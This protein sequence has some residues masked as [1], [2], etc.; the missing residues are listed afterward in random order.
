[1]ISKTSIVNGR[2]IKWNGHWRGYKELINESNIWLGIDKKEP[3]FLPHVMKLTFLL[4]KY[5]ITECCHIKDVNRLHTSRHGTTKAATLN[6]CNRCIC[7]SLAG[8]I[9]CVLMGKIKSI[10]KIWINVKNTFELILF[11][12]NTIFT[13]L[14]NVH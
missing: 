10:L 5:L 2:D 4:Q 8:E 13:A 11:R 7:P 3:I 14:R 12:F 6:K 9:L 1:M